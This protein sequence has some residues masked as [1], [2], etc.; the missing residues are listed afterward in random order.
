VRREF[1]RLGCNVRLVFGWCVTSSCVSVGT[2]QTVRSECQGQSFSQ[3][4]SQ[5]VLS[6]FQLPGTDAVLP[7]ISTFNTAQITEKCCTCVHLIDE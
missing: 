6:T 7:V 5:S 3:S 4:V 1:F 2:C